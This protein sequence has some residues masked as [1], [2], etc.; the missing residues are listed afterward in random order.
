[1]Y[2]YFLVSSFVELVPIILSQ[3]GVTFFLSE[4]LCQDPLEKL[5]GR[6]R[7]RGGTNDN[8]MAHEVFTNTQALRVV[9][10]INVKSIAGNCRGKKRTATFAE[11]GAPLQKCKQKRIKKK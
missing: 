8:P 2:A 11:I 5:F 3:P 1:M 7:Q 10:D 6:Q 4:K 9:G